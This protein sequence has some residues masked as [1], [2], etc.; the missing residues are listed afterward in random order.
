ML[1]LNS[2][3]CMGRDEE[4]CVVDFLLES[5]SNRYKQIAK[6]NR[7]HWVGTCQTDDLNPTLETNPHNSH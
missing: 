3:F 4:M 1:V 2:N 5:H 6:V 7:I